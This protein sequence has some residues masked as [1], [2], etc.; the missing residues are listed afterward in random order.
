MR[1]KLFTLG[2]Y[3]DKPKRAK[4]DYILSRTSGSVFNRLL[5]RLDSYN[6]PIRFETAKDCLD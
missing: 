3:D 6:V 2:D 5:V 1:I 4:L